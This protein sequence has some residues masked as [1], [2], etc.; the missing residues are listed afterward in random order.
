MQIMGKAQEGHVNIRKR[1][2]VDS[3]VSLDVRAI[4]RLCFHPRAAR[5]RGRGRGRQR[6]TEGEHQALSVREI[7][8]ISQQTA[9]RNSRVD[10]RRTQLI[11]AGFDV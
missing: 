6:E 5:G 4:K 2:A 10:I 11:L 7:G 8:V 9:A 3:I 1:Q